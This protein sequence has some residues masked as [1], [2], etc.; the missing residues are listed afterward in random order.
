[1]TECLA[2]PWP[3]QIRR[4]IGGGGNSERHTALARMR[5]RREKHGGPDCME[6]MPAKPPR[7]PSN[8]GASAGAQLSAR[9]SPKSSAPW[10]APWLPEVVGALVPG[11]H[12]EDDD[13]FPP[14]PMMPAP[15]GTGRGPAPPPG[16]A[17]I[18]R[19]P[20]RDEGRGGGL[21][22]TPRSGAGA[23]RATPRR[24]DFDDEPPRSARGGGGAGAGRVRGPA[25]ALAA[26]S[27]G[28]PHASEMEDP[29]PPQAKG[30]DF[31]TLQAMIAKG[32][33][34][35]EVGASSLEG[36]LAPLGG[37]DDELARHREAVRRRKEED[38][39]GKQREKEVAKEKRRKENEA[40][41]RRLQDEMEQEE[42]EVLRQREQQKSNEALCRRQMAAASR[43]QA[44]VRGRRSRAGK[45]IASPVVAPKLHSEP[46][47]AMGA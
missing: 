25:E 47:T 8:R 21:A 6:D 41:V 22:E 38:S 32:I 42:Q 7:P 26:R 10:A 20:R 5:A 9:S 19:T 14:K 40:R 29:L 24:D 31:R 44:L 30:A 33:Q 45:S 15:P 17:D 39:A 46:W 43:I 27:G 16:A 18:M 12:D 13:P 28:T 34:D 37:D 1:M 2:A 23:A 36:D 3:S 4:G 11:R 35:A